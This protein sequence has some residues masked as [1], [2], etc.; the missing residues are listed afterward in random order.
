MFRRIWVWVNKP[1]VPRERHRTS[2][3]KCQMQ[4]CDAC[5]QAWH[6][7]DCKP[8][9]DDIKKEEKVK[10]VLPL[11]ARHLTPLPSAWLI[12]VIIFQAYP[13]D[14]RH[15]MSGCWPLEED[16][17]LNDKGNTRV[18]QC[19]SENIYSASQRGSVWDSCSIIAVC[20]YG[21]PDG[22]AWG[23]T[24]ANNVIYHKSQIFSC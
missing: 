1:P 19:T 24:Q 16:K 8:L 9:T 23:V 15:A 17:Q 6:E 3:G 5:K 21:P 12:H 10:I 14:E 18:Y 2:C 11:N 22:P 13:I 4:Y 7:G 20:V